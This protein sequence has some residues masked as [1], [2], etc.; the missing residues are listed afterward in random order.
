[1]PFPGASTY[2]LT[3]KEILR[4]VEAADIAARHYSDHARNARSLYEVASEPVVRDSID[5]FE[6]T[7]REYTELQVKLRASRTVTVEEW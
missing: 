7:A 5:L 3:D 4:L 2:S 6:Q 1:V